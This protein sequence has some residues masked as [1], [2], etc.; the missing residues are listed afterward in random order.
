MGVK[1]ALVSDTFLPQVGGLEVHVSGLAREL[2]A[3]G[4]EPHVLCLTPDSEPGSGSTSVLP[5]PVH[6]LAVPMIP[7]IDRM[8]HP[9][10][11]GL[12]EQAI[13]DGG[14]DLVHGHCIFSPMAHAAMHAAARLSIPS[15]LT[16][17]SVLRGVAFSILRLLDKVMPWS[18]W[19]TVFTGVSQLV[20]AET[21]ACAGRTEVRTLPNA[22]R[23]LDWQVTRRPERR[24]VTVLR[25]SPRKRPMDLVRIAE[26]ICSSL[27]RSLWPVFTLIGDGPERARVAH[28]VQRR[29]LQSQF[30]LTGALRQDQ[31]RDYLA[32]SL[33]F[34]MPSYEEA[35]SIAVIE[36]RAAGLPVVARTGNGIADLI[37]DGKQGFL[38]PDTDSFVGAVLALLQQPALCDRMSQ[39]TLCGLERFDWSHCMDQHLKVY[40]WAMSVHAQ[41]SG[42][43]R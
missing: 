31:I 7:R 10:G 8:A 28:E 11:L 19:P 4:H 20:S 30:E 37:E 5:F 3:R 36:A 25:M 9:R 15:V 29:G 33:V 43:I 14:Y 35:L 18:R 40:E 6:R 27:P 22:V 1:V 24:I 42:S 34:V 13:A 12:V 26:R 41:R 17:H 38:A 23:L 32:R 2:S 21:R 16:V 39:E